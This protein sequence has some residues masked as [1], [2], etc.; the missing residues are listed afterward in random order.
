MHQGCVC[1]LNAQPSDAIRLI[2]SG[3]DTRELTG[4]TLWIPFFLSHLARAYA[5]LGK[6][7]DAR[8]SI[9]EAMTTVERTKEGWC[10]PEAYRTAGEVMLLAPGARCGESGSEFQSRAHNCTQAG[11]KNLGTTR[12]DEHGATLARSGKARRGSQSS[13]SDLWLVH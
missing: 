10:E 9:H 1:A 7:E 2:T 3:M 6:F 12:G 4:A 13:C 8:R 11:G 5:A